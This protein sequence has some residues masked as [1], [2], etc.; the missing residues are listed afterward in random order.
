[1]HW[2]LRVVHLA[3]RRIILYDSL[4]S[5]DNDNRLKDVIIPLAKLLPCILHVISYYGEIGDPKSDQQWDIEQL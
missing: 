2:V 1:M 4:I 3:Q 5:I